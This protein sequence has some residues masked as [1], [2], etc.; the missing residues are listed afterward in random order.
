[1]IIFWKENH[2]FL[3]EFVGVCEL[4]APRVYGANKLAPWVLCAIRQF[5]ELIGILGE[6]CTALR[7]QSTFP[8]LK[9]V[10]AIGKYKK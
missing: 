6:Q 2:C 8:F 3:C 10:N 5:L 7:M 9:A 4:K 1:M